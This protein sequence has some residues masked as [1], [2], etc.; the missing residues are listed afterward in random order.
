MLMLTLMLVIVIEIALATNTQRPTPNI[1]HPIEEVRGRKSAIRG[2][3]KQ[4]PNLPTP[5]A[6]NSISE[7]PSSNFDLS[8][9]AS[10]RETSVMQGREQVF[11]RRR[12]GAKRMEDSRLHR[13]VVGLRRRQG[14]QRINTEHRTS[15]AHMVECQCG[16]GKSENNFSP[17]NNNV[18]LRRPA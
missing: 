6:S 9:L 1:Q 14:G 17:R 16:A 11:T 18:G 2:I 4:T 15:D 3:F 10:L 7:L 13:A 8:G 5:N 12:K